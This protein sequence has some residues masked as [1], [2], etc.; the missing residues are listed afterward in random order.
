MIDAAAR[1]QSDEAGRGDTIRCSYHVASTASADAL[2]I[3]EELCAQALY[4]PAQ[5]PEWV[6][7]WVDHVQ[8]DGLIAHISCDGRPVFALALE[9]RPAGPFRIARFMG[10]SHANGNFPP[11]AR[12][13]P[14]T[15]E[16]RLLID[17]L[18]AARP[19]VD[20]VVLARNTPRFDRRD[21]ALLLLPHVQ[22]PNIALSVN[23][24]G[25]FEAVLGRASTRSKRKRHRAEIRKFETLG[26]YR[27]VEAKSADEARW[28]L[29]TFLDMKNKRFRA[30]GIA[31][32]FAD[33]RIQAFFHALFADSLVTG[34][35]S[36][37][38]EGL[39]VG[40]KLRAVTG[41]SHCGGRMTCEFGAIYD[42]ELA[43]SSPGEFLF[44]ENIEQACK[45]GY[46]I[47]DFGI[48]DEP[49]KRLWCDIETHHADVILP[50]SAKGH[51]L[52]TGMK[53]AARLEAGLKNNAPAWRLTK[54]LRKRLAAWTD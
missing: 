10:G 29:Y 54:S 11:L 17:A 22:S 32:V 21:N 14:E 44:Y 6:R 24:K 36:F 43:A 28:L 37:T 45:A 46:D 19:D 16:I 9:I 25:G 23:L 1:R 51:I 5:S 50:L 48:G 8:P 39:E 38:L 20:A 26:G 47:Y 31:N 12:A 13:W 4:A 30:M 49:Y 3:Y 35:R 15:P 18:A 40:G 7:S 52:A 42:D 53:A 34:S 2:P 33:A 27:R 41:T